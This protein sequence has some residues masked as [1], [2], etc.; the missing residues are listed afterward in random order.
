MAGA[1]PRVPVSAADVDYDGL[2]RL[3]GRR[4]VVVGAGAGIGEHVA[5]TIHAMGASLVLVD[6]HPEPLGALAR[7]LGGVPVVADASTED[8][9]AQIAAV[10]AEAGHIDGYV[11]V[12]GQMTRKPLREFTLDDWE[13]DFR[14]N[15]THAFLTGQH[16]APLVA[17]SGGG[18][19]VYVSSVKAGHAGR[20]AAGYGPAKA[21]LQTWVKQLAAEY[22]PEGVRVNAVA[23]GLFLSPRFV[24]HQSPESI[25]A[26]FAVHA[27]L[28]R[29]GQPFEVAATIAFLLTP[30]A[31]YITATTIPIEGGSL[32]SDSTGL[33]AIPFAPPQAGRA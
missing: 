7:E 16:L 26:N 5:R 10:A 28:G 27:M 11:D 13:R 21:A 30:A 8:G 14:V 17:A 2:F 20:K 24:A 31:G 1:D 32:S 18:S 29:L 19:I 6:L 3:D 22:G 4:Y 15:L 25:D 9:A 33:D 23:P 12:I